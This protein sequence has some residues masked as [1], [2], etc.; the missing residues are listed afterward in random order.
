MRVAPRIVL[1]ILP[2][3]DRSPGVEA[4]SFLAFPLRFKNMN[5]KSIDQIEEEVVIYEISDEAVEAAGTRAEIAGVW[6]FICTGIQCGHLF[7][8]KQ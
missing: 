6:T 4:F 8:L 7:A 5:E 2:C 1:S 3:L